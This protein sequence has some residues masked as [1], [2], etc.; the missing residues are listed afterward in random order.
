[1]T[2]LDRVNGWNVTP[3]VMVRTARAARQAL[4][5]GADGVVITHG[6]DTTE[7]TLYL[8]DLGRRHRPGWDRR[9]LCHAVGR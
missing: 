7:E 8:V 9:G 4:E 1:M 3:D 2:E 6:T 5:D